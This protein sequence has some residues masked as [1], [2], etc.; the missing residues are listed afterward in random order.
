[1]LLLSNLLNK[2]IR[3]G[4]MHLTDANGRQQVFGGKGPGPDVH[5]KLHD[6]ALHTK[7]FLNPELHAGEAYMDGT[8]TFGEGSTVYDFLYLFSINRAGLGAHQSQKLMRTLWRGLKRRQQANPAKVAAAN[9]RHHYDLSTDLYRL[10]L[11]EGLNYSCAFFEDPETDTLEEAQRN[12]LRRITTK[13]K[14]EPGMTVAEIGSGWGSLAIELAK[15]GA[16]VTAINV[17]PE[18]LRI[19]RERAETAGVADLIDF[20]ELDYRALEGRFDRV[21]SV[22]MM[23]HVGIGH[24]DDY[25]S[26]IG[27]LLGE[28]G[29]AFVHCIGRMTPP[30]T[31]GPF[32][33]KYIFPGGYVPA[34][35]EVFAATERVGMWVADMEVLRLHYYYTI[36]HW[37]ERFE[38]RRG[39]AASLYDERFCRMWEFYLC[40][41]ELGF[42]NGSNM[43]FQLLLSRK[44]DAVPIVRDFMFK[45][46]GTAR[47]AADG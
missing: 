22:G 14:L 30:G 6:K 11:D 40:A 3:N 38:A 7:L 18:Q 5:V 21:V 47:V 36:K 42:L 28:D 33:R 37:R 32:I 15:S 4:T 24:F 19:A 31:T 26:K 12:K 27:S 39:D 45:E 43:V 8:L 46:P 10:F 41:V 25:F 34:L 44:R 2:F 35:S 9:A 29:Y 13:L 20:R 16:R 1:M 17:S 23:E